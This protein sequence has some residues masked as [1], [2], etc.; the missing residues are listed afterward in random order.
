MYCTKWMCWVWC[1][2]S[3]LVS[4]CTPTFSLF[5]CFEQ[6]AVLKDYTG[7]SVYLKKLQEWFATRPKIQQENPRPCTGFQYPFSW[8][9]LKV[10]LLPIWMRI[11]NQWHQ[12]SWTHS[13]KANLPWPRKIQTSKLLSKKKCQTISNM[14][15]DDK[16][17]SELGEIFCGC[18]LREFTG[19]PKYYDIWANFLHHPPQV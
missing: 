1:H 8:E 18:W 13:W 14:S 17:L 2:A 12:R 11:A 9:I 6:L 4:W 3:W 10:A 19:V 5:R 15:K 16:D 7:R